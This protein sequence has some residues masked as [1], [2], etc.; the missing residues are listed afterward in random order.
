MV[1]ISACRVDLRE[2]GRGRNML[3]IGYKFG[4]E[5]EQTNETV[6]EKEYVAKWG[7]S[8]MENNS[9]Y[10]SGEGHNPVENRKWC[11][12]EGVISGGGDFRREV[13]G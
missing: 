10:L 3:S 7:I 2:S 13:S 1:G 11:K 9:A 4:K 6:K 8:E 5:E 12:Q